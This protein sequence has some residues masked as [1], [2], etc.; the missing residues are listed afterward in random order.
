MGPYSYPVSYLIP[1]P[2]SHATIRRLRLLN[3]RQPQRVF[4]V[5]DGLEFPRFAARSPAIK[6]ANSGEP[7]QIHL[8]LTGT[9]GEMLV[10]WVSGPVEVPR[11]RWAPE[12]EGLEAA[13]WR[14]TDAETRTYTRA[15][16]CGAPA[17]G[18]GWLDPGS[19]HAA[20]LGGLRPGRRYRYVVGSEAG[21]WSAPASF[22]AGAGPDEEVAIIATADLGQTEADGSL[23]VD[24][25]APASRQTTDR[26]AAEE[27][28]ASL[29]VRG[30]VV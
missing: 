26:L 19:L 22:Q 6:P 20:R 28:N 24:A 12:E 17:N 10:Q 25:I 3:I 23:E 14:T 5:R 4:L 8:A 29:L 27:L 30:W 2:H 9:P 7:T 13:A 11:V 18:S 16:L 1:R 15:D 21:G